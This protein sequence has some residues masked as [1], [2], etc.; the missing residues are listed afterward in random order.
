MIL[1]NKLD[2]KIYSK[3]RGMFPVRAFNV[4][5]FDQDYLQYEENSHGDGIVE[6]DEFIKFS[7]GFYSENNNPDDAEFEMRIIEMESAEEIQLDNLPQEYR[8]VYDFLIELGIDKIS[9]YEK[10][11]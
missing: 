3:L 9:F 4:F 8:D 6:V 1:A 11:K 10:E 5:I 7:F 2:Y